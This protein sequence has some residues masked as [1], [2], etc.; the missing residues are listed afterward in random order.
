MAATEEVL[1]IGGGI[2]G[3][4]L[5][6]QLHQAGIASRVFEAAPDLL[7]LG[8]GINLLPHASKELWRLGLQDRMGAFSVQTSAAVF[9]NRFGQHVHT[10]PAGSNAGYPYPQ[11]STHRGLLQLMLAEAVRERIGKD[12]LV[13]DARA[14]AL[15]Y[16][17]GQA[18]VTTEDSS[19]NRTERSAPVIVGCDGVHSVLRRA[20][21]PTD[22]APLYSGVT[23]WRGTTR[24][25]PF[26]DGASM[27]RA[28]WL[29][30]GKMVIYP[31]VNYDD[32]T[33]LVNWVAELEVPQRHNRDWNQLASVDDF[34]DPFKDWTFDWLDVPAMLRG[35]DKIYEYPMV[36]QNPLP[37][38]TRGCVTLLGDAAHPM[39]PRGSNGAGQA[40]LDT[41]S[42]VDALVESTDVTEA[43]ARYESERL[44]RTSEVV[45]LNRVNPPDALLREVYERTGD[46][47]FDRIEAVIS[48][49]DVTELLERYRTVT[50]S[51]LEAV[52][53]SRKAGH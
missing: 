46:K 38:W 1:I 11:Y 23:M 52:T 53:G 42:L 30:T 34:I 33:Q 2:G 24:M 40:I 19:G 22:T 13:L 20:L 12:A 36:D 44:P 4:T 15:E 8:V 32:G 7:P 17:D 50:G 5:A 35:A 29:A 6:L 3:L 41:R 16:D 37:F 28:G 25:K 47:P 14:V 10:D 49:A 48:S 18:I 9:Y 26:L 43:L 31:I 45:R 27:V 21:H 39:V 51:S